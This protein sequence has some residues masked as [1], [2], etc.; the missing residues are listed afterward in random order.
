MPN[1]SIN[2]LKGLIFD[3]HLVARQERFTVS[4]KNIL[5]RKKINLIKNFQSQ[6]YFESKQKFTL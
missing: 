1:D 2:I 5:Y 3:S 4:P 6:K